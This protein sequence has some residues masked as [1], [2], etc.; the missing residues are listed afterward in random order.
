MAN[1]NTIDVLK[2]ASKVVG[3]KLP[4]H[5][6]SK[7]LNHSDDLDIFYIEDA[8]TIEADGNDPITL[9]KI[10]DQFKLINDQIKATEYQL[11]YKKLKYNHKSQ[12]WEM[13]WEI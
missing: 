6:N 5:I 10:V 3:S 4:V 11:Y 8:Y 9:T 1:F 13:Q 12:F 7:I 2:F